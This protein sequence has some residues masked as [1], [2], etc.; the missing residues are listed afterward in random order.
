MSIVSVEELERNPS[1][2]LERVEAGESLI[3]ERGGRPVAELRPVAGRRPF[4]L[5]A[6]AFVVPDDFDAALPDE[7]LR[8]FEGR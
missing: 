3:V 7:T 8:E 2:L 4:G 1:A 5:C 6:G